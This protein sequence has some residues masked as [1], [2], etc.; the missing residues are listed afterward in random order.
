MN[1]PYTFVTALHGNEVFPSLALASEGVPQFIGN[2]SA[3]AQIQRFL[4]QDLNAAFGALGETLEE[5]R[6][7]EL[8]QLIPENQLVVDFHT[9]LGQSPPFC[10]LVDIQQLDLAKKTGISR[11]VLMTH[12]IKGGHALI[13]HRAGISIEVGSHQDPASFRQTLEV[14]NQLALKT[15]P[16]FP[17]S[18]FEVYDTIKEPG[19]YQNFILFSG[20]DESFYPIL[21]GQNSYAHYG[22]KARL[23]TPQE[24]EQRK[25]GNL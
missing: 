12:N 24:I 8:L 10:I 21:S 16:E 4:E 5:R 9:F 1:L 13:N 6:A 11:A 7:R 18:V 17:L 22:L 23:L 2:P 15:H 19:T 14:I 25:Q 20:E 3:V